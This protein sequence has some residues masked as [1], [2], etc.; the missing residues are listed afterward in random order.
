VPRHQT[1]RTYPPPLPE[2]ALY[3][4]DVVF[5]DTD[6][7]QVMDVTLDFVMPDLEPGEYY[8][9][10]CNDPCS[11]Q[12]GDTMSTAITVVA[13]Q[14]QAFLASRM[15][16]QD[17]VLFNL[18]YRAREEMNNLRGVTGRLERTVDSMELKIASLER[19]LELASRPESAS[20]PQSLWPWAIGL[21]SLG[22][23]LA[24]TR[25][26]LFPRSET[27]EALGATVR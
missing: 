23:L 13:D 11:R 8:L 24:W 18:R 6:D 1:D 16:R 17:R 4:G 2:N 26:R 12:I 25:P 21:A 22:L 5:S 19:R 10:H 27:T 15:Y 3:V 7:Q 20:E 14:G 9:L